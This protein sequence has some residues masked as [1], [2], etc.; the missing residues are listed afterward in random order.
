M[1]TMVLKPTAFAS[2]GVPLGQYRS[3]KFGFRRL[4][5]AQRKR[6]RAGAANHT[7]PC[8]RKSFARRPAA[9]VEYRRAN[10]RALRS[11]QYDREPGPLYER[12]K[13]LITCR[14]Q[15]NMHLL[16][17]VPPPGLAH[18]PTQLAA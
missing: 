8:V 2:E 17:F 15:Y 7:I 16:L 10:R 4:G 13:H 11:Y 6:R 14:S 5:I 1:L 18:L 9:G 12:I 3:L